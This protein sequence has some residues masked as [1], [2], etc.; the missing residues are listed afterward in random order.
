MPEFKPFLTWLK[1]GPFVIQE[2]FEDSTPES[3]MSDPETSV[4]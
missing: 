3:R 4:M 2:Q 1:S